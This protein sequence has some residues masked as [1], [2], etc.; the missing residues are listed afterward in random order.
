[1]NPPQ[2]FAFAGLYGHWENPGQVPIDSFT[3]ITTNANNKLKPLH[4][5][6][7]VILSPED[8]GFWLDPEN[9]DLD[10][11]KY[12]LRPRGDEEISLYPV[13]DR[14]NSPKNDTEDCIKPIISTS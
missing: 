11:L 9:R 10:K 12:L 2:P 6:M 13:S 8:E 3:I 4:D 5:R 1:L 14:V 7:P